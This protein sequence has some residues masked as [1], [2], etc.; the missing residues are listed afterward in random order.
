MIQAL[1]RVS[2][3]G[4]EQRSNEVDAVD[5]FL[6]IYGWIKKDLDG[7]L[8]DDL[9]YTPDANADVDRFYSRGIRGR[10]AVGE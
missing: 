4:A 10:G 7:L 1:E 2:L 8:G 6:N 5:T 9:G 3:E